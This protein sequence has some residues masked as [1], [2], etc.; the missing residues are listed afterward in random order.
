MSFL[1]SST[2]LRV[3]IA[4]FR[5]RESFE[6][7]KHGV[8]RRIVVTHYAGKMGPAHLPLLSPCDRSELVEMSKNLDGLPQLQKNAHKRDRVAV[9]SAL[10][11]IAA[12]THDDNDV[13]AAP[14]SV[15]APAAAHARARRARAAGADE[16]GAN[17]RGCRACCCKSGRGG[18]RCPGAT[19]A[20][21][22]TVRARA[23]TTIMQVLAPH[24]RT[25]R[26]LLW[27]R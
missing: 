12:A 10:A 9:T 18:A 2:A 7:D 19:R 1:N 20:T 3:V 14:T 4:R 8:L 22:R 16:T 13:A 15:A 27:R 26:E 5:S 21:R 25:E 24:S 6:E 23:R 17:A 11:R